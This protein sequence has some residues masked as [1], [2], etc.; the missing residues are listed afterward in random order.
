MR[1]RQLIGFLALAATLSAAE[2]YVDAERGNDSNNGTSPLK[3]WKTLSKINGR[4]FQPGD[5]VRFHAG[6][7]WHGQ[8]APTSSGAEGS[9]IVISRYSTGAKPRID[10]GG[11]V[12]DAIRLTNVEHIEVGD[13]EVTNHGDQAALRRGVHI[14][15][16]N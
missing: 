9:P 14:V 15:N 13:L 10:G 4:K 12:E 5:V 16:D 1:C 2:Y 11:I 3:A 8:L 7:A 6:Q